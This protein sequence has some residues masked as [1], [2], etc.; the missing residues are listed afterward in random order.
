MSFLETQIKRNDEEFTAKYREFT[1][2]IE[3]LDRINKSYREAIQKLEAGESAIHEQV[4]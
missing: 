4:F 1:K 3:E 2:Q